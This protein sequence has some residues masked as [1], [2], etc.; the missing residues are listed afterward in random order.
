M[1]DGKIFTKSNIRVDVPRKTVWRYL[2]SEGSLKRIIDLPAEIIRDTEDARFI[3]RISIDGHRFYVRYEENAAHLSG[4]GNY[5]D[6]VLNDA[7]E[8][9][10]VELSIIAGGES[11]L[12]ISENK[13]RGFLE[14][15]KAEID[16]D[17]AEKTAAEDAAQMPADKP[18]EKLNEKPADEKKKKE[19]PSDKKTSANDAPILTNILSV[20]V[21]L[22]LIATAGYF[23]YKYVF[24][25]VYD[26]ASVSASACSEKVTYENT[27]M[28]ELG[29]SQSEVENI[30]GI[31]GEQVEG[32]TLYC[33][34][35]LS[36]GIPARQ[37]LIG[38][39]KHI[40]SSITYLDMNSARV[41]LD[42][43]FTLKGVYP[44][45]I[46]VDA[47]STAAN[48]PVSMYRMFINEN[49]ER[50]SEVHFG[51]VDP[52]ANF[53]EAWRGQ[54]VVT[55]N[56]E[57]AKVSS[58][59]WVVYGAGD[60]LTVASLE[61]SVLSRQYDSYTDY[62]NDKFALDE[63]MIMK[64]KF[65]RGDV[66]N[67]FGVELS[68]YYDGTETNGTIFYGADSSELIAGT[69]TPARRMSFGYDTLGHFRMCSLT[70]MR[71]INTR[72]LLTGTAYETVS[73]GM[74]YNE[75]RSIIGIMPTA[76]YFDES[77]YT[78]CYGRL[79]DEA[80][81]DDQF[82]LVVRLSVADDKVQAV[83]N[84]VARGEALDAQGS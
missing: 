3:R 63:M 83:Y 25:L 4:E 43:D 82:E 72:G 62:L 64:N 7:G 54:L 77:C 38:Y 35:E 8:A 10:G 20:A 68:I 76:I 14:R 84:N 1:S 75:V 55:A 42:G 47:I 27:V 70:N 12:T 21:A 19:K 13:A 71:F 44:A 36:S 23:G 24:P 31:T 79:I 67:L 5:I 2:L 57:T 59:G 51:Y 37:V 34:T 17:L 45:D 11:S 69:D 41:L 56:A 6:V 78:V 26:G 22:L 53:N 48:L 73:K 9:T 74:S 16:G 33:S 18:A 29:F 40:I 66:K 50:I 52:Y 65:T 30:F 81:A 15:L 60:G 80:S 39:D 58:K 49:A 46:T 61:D 28:L 32:K